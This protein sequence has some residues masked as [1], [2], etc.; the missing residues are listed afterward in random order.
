MHLSLIATIVYHLLRQGLPTRTD[1][2]WESHKL[3]K[4][5]DKQKKP[6]W[7]EVEWVF[8]MTCNTGNIF[9]NILLKNIC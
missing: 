9:K 4:N 2:F 5:I 8:F 3:N 6:T 7:I 1:A